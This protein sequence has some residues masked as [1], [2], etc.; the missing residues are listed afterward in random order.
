MIK[1]NQPDIN[2]R[3]LISVQN[4]L[5]SNN[6]TQGKEIYE[7]E[8]SLKVYCN[9]KYAKGVNS[10]AS[11]LH[12]SCLSL[13]VGRG[14]FVWMPGIT[15]VSDA[16]SAIFCGAKVKFIDIDKSTFNISEI[17]LEKELVKA[18]KSKKLPKAIIVVHLGGN[19]CNLKKIKKLSIKYNFK[20]IEDASHALGSIYEKSKI[21]SCKYSNLTV[22]SF[23][24]LKNITTGEGGAVLT[25]DKEI[26]KKINL[27]RSHGINRHK[28]KKRESWYYEQDLLGYNYRLTNFQA[29]LGLSQIKRLNSF[30]KKRNLIANRYS[31]L[32]SN[33]IHI[34]KINDNCFSA[35]HLFIILLPPKIKRKVYYDLKKNG[36]QSS[37]HY[38]PIYKHPYHK[39]ANKLKLK[40]CEFY[41]SRALSL[42]IHTHIKFADQLKIVKIITD[43]KETKNFVTL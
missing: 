16:N 3:D 10:A 35:Y 31:K 7:F 12:L 1:Y 36:I 34:Q 21:G 28:F 30:L 22:F 26:D 15:F 5:K 11:A 20:I 8:K 14:D 17:E 41:N 39:K 25:N 19:P 18:K 38:M 32:F 6:L 24:A 29:A 33:K 4:V 42:P 27:L 40:N 37:F 2:K 9:S 23:H 13:G 43:V